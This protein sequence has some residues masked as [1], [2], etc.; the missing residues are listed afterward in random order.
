MNLYTFCHFAQD[1]FGAF[2]G[3]LY[4]SICLRHVGSGLLLLD[5]I[6]FKQYHSLVFE[7]RY[8][9]AYQFVWYSNMVNNV[10]WDE[11]YNQLRGEGRI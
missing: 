9:I 5:L 3:C 6:S 2:I 7:I 10:G 4:S 1:L 8:V 11:R